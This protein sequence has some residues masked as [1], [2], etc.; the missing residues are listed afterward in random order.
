[1]LRW[2]GVALLAGG[3]VSLAVG[4]AL[5]WA[6]PVWEREAFIGLRVGTNGVT[7]PVG[8]LAESLV[9]EATARSLL[10]KVAVLPL[11]G[12]LAGVSIHWGRIG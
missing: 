12:A 4:I 11:V 3:G 6:V 5:N 2:P 7:D 1:M 8:G 10:E 9:R